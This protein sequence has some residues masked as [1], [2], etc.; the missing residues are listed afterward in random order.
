MIIVSR[1]LGVADT[2]P[3]Q[4]TGP[5]RDFVAGFAARSFVDPGPNP[6][7]TKKRQPCFCPAEF[8][9][10]TTRATANVLRIFLAVLDLDHLTW[11]DAANVGAR[12]AA[13]ASFIYST[14]S[15]TDG[16]PK[17][18]AV[19]L[20]SRPVAAAEW[21]TF[22]PRMNTFFG[23]VADQACKD[24][25][26]LY[27]GPFAP[28]GSEGEALYVP[29]AGPPLDV[30][31]IL[32]LPAPE[33]AT[34]AERAHAPGRAAALPFAA[35]VPMSERVSA[36]RAYLAGLPGA[37]SGRQGHRASFIAAMKIVRGFDLNEEAAFALLRDEWNS[38]CEPPWS[39]AD[40]RHK[41]SEAAEKSGMRRGA[42]LRPTIR[43]GTELHETIDQGVDAL[44][45]DPDVYQREGRLVHVVHADGTERDRASW[46]RG[47]PTIRPISEATVRERL[48]AVA[49]WEKHD[50]RSDTWNKA[51]P[52]DHVVRGVLA[53]GEWRGIPPIVG[54][55]EAP[56]FRPDGSLIDQPGHDAA[57]GY[58]YAPNAE[59][60]PLANPASQADA[61]A[62]FAALA[63]VFADFPYRTDAER[64]V[65][66]AA[67]LTL[68]A[69]PMIAGSVPA[70]LFDASTRGSGKTLQTDVIATVAT[71][72]AAS[73][74]NWPATDEE[75]E[76][77]L[78]SYALRG[79]RLINF[80]NVSRPIGGAPLEKCLTAIDRV[81]LRVLGKSETPELAWRATVL[82]SG[83]N[84]QVVG[85]T[86]RRVL[87]A[88]LEPDCERPEDRTQFRHPQ[89]LP[90]VCNDRIRLVHASL[91][92]LA[93]FVAAGRPSTVRAWGGFDAWA[94]I[95]PAAILFAG[96]ADVLDARP[97]DTDG[98]DPE[99]HALATILDALAR[100]DVNG[101]GLHLRDL[102]VRLTVEG[103]AGADA[104]DAAATLAPPDKDG[105][106]DPKLL[107]SRLRRH[108]GRVI[109]GRR[110]ARTVDGK[111]VA[112]WRAEPLR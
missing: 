51:L 38:R 90:W 111:G 47:T 98:H 9:P 96:G 106:I 72:R 85:D 63:E 89:L 34:S 68:I 91:T 10:G 15:H 60:P 107:G 87:I 62:A 46:A 23:G 43:I 40:L 71:G 39:D 14:W 81:D 41:V 26:H 67:I 77:V 74:M 31:V 97:R 17:L 61:R 109:G 88:R 79:A 58:L 64:C 105:R 30:D 112:R 103:I 104:L 48:T 16:A 42:L 70:F 57:T 32:N 13:F 92:I 19:V 59:Y 102:V 18:R 25:A 84:L 65:P 44:A 55:I 6:S 45:A 73:R 21:A 83:N 52:T 29:F 36:A 35:S 27:I 37:V 66:I 12:V 3:K 2:V 54:V 56:S 22:W 75:L 93:A 1:F 53:R 76:K 101:L 28:L 94:S 24:P 11:T 80:D 69:R 5:W 8:A 108:V 82:A 20:L 78:A 33:P 4:W 99:A 100:H 7:E 95:V 49:T 110:I 86:T 50:K